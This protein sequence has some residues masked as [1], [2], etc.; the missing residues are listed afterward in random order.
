MRYAKKKKKKEKKN[1]TTK[2]KRLFTHQKMPLCC[3]KTKMYVG[4]LIEV[5]KA[6]LNK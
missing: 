5:Q 6:F 4:Y 3:L 2:S 1:D